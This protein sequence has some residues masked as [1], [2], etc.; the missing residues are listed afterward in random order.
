MVNNKNEDDDIVV[1]SESDD[2]IEVQEVRAPAQHVPGQVPKPVSKPVPEPVPEPVQVRPGPKHEPVDVAANVVDLTSDT[3]ADA[4]QPTLSEEEI[5]RQRVLPTLDEH[6]RNLAMQLLERIQTNKLRFRRDYRDNKRILAS[7]RANIDG[8]HKRIRMEGRNRMSEME[9]RLFQSWASAQEQRVR[10]QDVY[11]SEL[12]DLN[13]VLSYVRKGRV[14]NYGLLLSIEVDRLSKVDSVFRMMDEEEGLRYVRG[15]GDGDGQGHGQVQVQGQGHA[16]QQRLGQ[17][18]PRERLPRGYDA[19]TFPRIHYDGTGPSARST[20]G[21]SGMGTPSLFSGPKLGDVY[22]TQ[23]HANSR[24]LANLLNNIS[25]DDIAKDKRLGTPPELDVTLL[26]HQKIGLTWLK[27]IEESTRGGILADDMGLGKTIQ[28][29]AL[30]VARPPPRVSGKIKG[31]RTTLIVA[32]VALIYQWEQELLTKIKSEHRL[33]ILVYHGMNRAKTLREPSE[34]SRLDVLITSYGV[35]SQEFKNHFGPDAGREHDQGDGQPPP[36]PGTANSLFYRAEFYRIILDE[37]QYIKNKSTLASMACA[38]L[39]AR[40]RWC[41]SGTPMQNKVDELYSLLRFLRVEP[42]CDESKFRREILAGINAASAGSEATETSMAKLRA[43]L[44]AVLLRRTKDS[45]V[46]GQPILRLPP[47]TIEVQ[48]TDFSK[49]DELEYYK[50]LETGMAN[51]LNAYVRNDSVGS[52]YSSILAMLLRL[53]QAC[54]H[55]ALIERAKLHKAE[56]QARQRHTEEALAAARRLE[57]EVVTRVRAIDDFSCPICMDAVDPANVVLLFPCGHDMCSECATD[58]LQSARQRDGGMTKCLTCRRP[59][60]ESKSIDY[61][62][63]EMVHVQGMSDDAVRGEWRETRRRVQR[64]A[65]QRRALLAATKQRVEDAK[66]FEDDF[67]DDDK[68]NVNVKNE[69][70]DEVKD[71]FMDEN[72][73]DVDDDFNEF[74]DDSN[75]FDDQPQDGVKPEPSSTCIL[76]ESTVADQ[77]GLNE[78]FPKGWLSSTKI[79]LCL[80]RLDAIQNEFP[81]E[82]VIIFSQFTSFL[83]LLEVP[84]LSRGIEYLRYDGSMSS[85]DRTTAVRDFFGRPDVRV[86]LISL[87][88]GNVGLTLT[89][90]SHVILMDPF[91]NPFVE[92]QAMDR[93]HRI[94]QSRPV[95]VHRLLIKG[96]V[97]DRIMALQ[98]KK[99]ELINAALDETGLKKV[100]KLSRNELLFL[101]GLNPRGQR[102]DNVSVPA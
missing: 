28:L 25:D 5:F 97:E 9:S 76:D 36:R 1:L 33:S 10:K 47:K 15:G 98:K 8:L 3:T 37:A 95:F 48:E 11:E 78:L 13:A 77:M 55:P 96:T 27:K 67:K 22:D 101:F 38:R 44:K 17:A 18:H 66:L 94:G 89:C 50:T 23:G 46:D 31:P 53:R 60:D 57:P 62:T 40:Y 52:N 91:W 6:S 71:E 14:R 99:K 72:D 80:S 58:F 86:L 20:F 12:E 39:N 4:Q 7:L 70:K 42:Y 74:A 21:G 85:S 51:K 93:A 61:T 79:D 56:E 19:S 54:L 87:R 34:L 90:A 43:L 45:K 29:M 2:D 64:E 24:D 26:E 100:S 73:M 32:P 35:I 68:A 49:E 88:A 59:I 41:L 83:D 63:F 82:K 30:M 102:D 75:E 84:L 69:V 16:D 92:D 65:Q 81:G